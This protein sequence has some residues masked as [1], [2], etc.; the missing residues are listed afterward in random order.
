MKDIKWKEKYNKDLKNIFGEELDDK[1]LE[2]LEDAFNCIEKLWWRNFDKIKKPIKYIMI[3]EA[4]LYGEKFQYFYNT[5]TIFKSFFRFTDIVDVFD[6]KEKKGDN[7]I[8]DK[9]FVIET[10]NENGFVILDLFPFAFNK[11]DTGEINYNK[12]SKINI[13]KLFELSYEIVL[14]E[15]LET[16]LENGNKPIFFFRYKR[17][18]DKLGLE[19]LEKLKIQLSDIKED[20]IKCVSFR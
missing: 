18:K 7:I 20:D 14:K 17:L 5:K 15:K 12:I 19:L 1:K 8:K 16:I 2:Y 9:E 3:S 4:P 11:N 6:K 10:L 13:K